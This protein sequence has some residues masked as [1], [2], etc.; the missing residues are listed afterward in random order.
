[1]LIKHVP[2]KLLAFLLA[3]AASVAALLELAF[4]VAP[5]H[6]ILDFS[7]TQTDAGFKSGNISANFNGKSIVPNIYLRSLSFRSN[8]GDWKVVVANSPRLESDQRLFEVEADHLEY[9]EN[10]LEVRL[11][12]F[13]GNQRTVSHAFDYDG[14]APDF[15]IFNDWETKPPE[16]QDGFWEVIESATFGH[17]TRPV[18]GTEGYDRLALIA[19]PFQGGRRAIVDIRFVKATGAP[20]GFGFVPFWGG[21]IDEGEHFPRRGW[22][23]GIAWYYSH[24]K[25]F[26]VEFSNKEGPDPHT[27]IREYIPFQPTPGESYRLVAEAIV[28]DE[29]KSMRLKVRQLPDGQ[30]SEWITLTDENGLLSGTSHA[31]GLI[32]HRVQVEFGEIR[33]EKLDADSFQ[34]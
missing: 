30:F 15:P 16:V 2:K 23:Y 32:A 7:S 10:S 33:V 24:A 29:V 8:G 18:P 27:T 5:E 28:R 26:G 17:A 1:M 3:G 25:G 19:P 14:R 6:L 9:G 11:R 31:V 21:H 22:E 4:I 13:W 20:F 34:N 12:S